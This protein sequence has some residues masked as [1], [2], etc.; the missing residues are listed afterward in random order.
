VTN[1]RPSGL[2]GEAR[3]SEKGS[4]IVEFGLVILP[5]LAFL[6]LIVDVAW[7]LFAQST[8]QYA[9]SEGVR[10]AVT[11]QTMSGMGQDASIRTVVV[12]DA[13]GFVTSATASNDVA[14]NYYN[15]STLAATASNAGGN[16]V[17]VVIGG[18]SV[19][20]L[21]PI[22]RSSAAMVLSAR[23]SDVMESSPGGIPPAR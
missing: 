13:F 14:I 7:V 1:G 15:P 2:V 18:V 23:S 8:L 11:G 21:G 17:E 20:P 22:W 19:Y 3:N 12:N 16:V 10:Y 5:M 4:E 6:L 9:A